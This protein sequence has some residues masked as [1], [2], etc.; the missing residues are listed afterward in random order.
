MAQI[1]RA[2]RQQ[3]RME[4][5][6][7]SPQDRV[8]TYQELLDEALESTFPASDP[9]AAGAAT[10][11][12]E[13]RVTARDAHDWTLDPGSKA[14][15]ASVPAGEWSL[16]E[17]GWVATPMRCRLGD[18]RMVMLPAGRC[19]IRQTSDQAWLTWCIG[20]LTHSVML[21]LEQLQ[22]LLAAGVVVRDDLP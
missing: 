17:K 11:V 18:E 15:H 16:P 8:P 7:T 2:A 14:S 21:S 4:G 9:I 13:P 10:H 6:A 3:R 12:R 1:D 20:G 5:E 19:V 22:R